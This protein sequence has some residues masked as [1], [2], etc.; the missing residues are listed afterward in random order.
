M[1]IALFMSLL[2]LSACS[3]AQPVNQIAPSAGNVNAAQVR[4]LAKGNI[5][6]SYAYDT[7]YRNSPEVQAWERRGRMSNL[8]IINANRSP[9]TY[10]GR[11]YPVE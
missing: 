11:S 3:T 1:R 7:C 8:N 4:C 6:G 9:N 10:A 2:L 5:R